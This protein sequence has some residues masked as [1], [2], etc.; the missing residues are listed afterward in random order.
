MT[1]I[2]EAAALT[3]L[4]ENPNFLNGSLHNSGGTNP[5]YSDGN[6]NF[7]YGYNI[8]SNGFGLLESSAN[9][10]FLAG[11][12]GEADYNSLLN[13]LQVLENSPTDWQ[14][15]NNVLTDIDW[16][17]LADLVTESFIQT[18]VMP[19]LDSELLQY[20]TTLE[21]LPTGIQLA[22]IDLGYNSSFKNGYYTLLG[23]PGSSKMLGD[24]ASVAN[25]PT[26]Y[27]VAQVAYQIAF[28][29]YDIGSNVDRGFGDAAVAL[30]FDITLGGY[31]QITELSGTPNA[32]AVVAFMQ[33]LDTTA[34]GASTH[35]T[36]GTYL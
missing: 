12:I 27:N 19:N 24:L 18:E 21:A 11:G 13:A 35:V 15:A 4:F 5:F 26:G 2:L 28:N 29:T 31:N 10:F 20:N 9:L 3:E 33:L 8:T 23:S 22:V 36:I 17:P 30:G 14:H 16:R 25:S 1:N 34:A 6:I 32:L 7:G